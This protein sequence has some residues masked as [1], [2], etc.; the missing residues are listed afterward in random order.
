MLKP[1]VGEAN[2]SVL[3]ERFWN[4][5]N[6]IRKFFEKSDPLE[7]FELI[8]CGKLNNQFSPPLTDEQLVQ[9]KRFGGTANGPT[10]KRRSTPGI[11]PGTTNDNCNY[12]P[13]KSLREIVT[14]TLNQ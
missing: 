4:L 9:H 8:G 10:P 3:E 5:Q 1:S 11:C 12:N 2:V 7:H 14:D 6:I 13:N